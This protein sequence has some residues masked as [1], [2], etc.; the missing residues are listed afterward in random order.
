MFEDA[1]EQRFGVALHRK[2]T[3]EKQVIGGR[4]LAQALKLES[5]NGRSDPS[6]SS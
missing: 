6:R 4:Q 5:V 3:R 1:G 2:G